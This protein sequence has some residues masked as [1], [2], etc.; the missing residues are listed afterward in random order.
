M[1]CA[2]VRIYEIKSL[3]RQVRS[4]KRFL[5]WTARF[6][7]ITHAS[8]RDLALLLFLPS[9]HLYP[10]YWIKHVPACEPVHVQFS[11]ETPREIGFVAKKRHVWCALSFFTWATSLNQVLLSIREY[12]NQVVCA[13]CMQ[14]ES[15]R[16]NDSSKLFCLWSC[17]ST[18]WSSIGSLH[19]GVRRM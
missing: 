11:S 2:V 3:R 9:S 16:R 8:M 12:L 10:Q 13:E 15:Q 5:R 6:D 1:L 4:R 17:D 7:D 18:S 19:W 14:S